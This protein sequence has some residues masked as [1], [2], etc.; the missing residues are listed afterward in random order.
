MNKVL[1]MRNAKLV[2]QFCKALRL[3][4]GMRSVRVSV[5]KYVR[6]V[7]YAS[8]LLSFMLSYQ[9]KRGS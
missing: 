5:K 1:S 3:T 6:T 7:A 2:F 4:A 9:G 8:G